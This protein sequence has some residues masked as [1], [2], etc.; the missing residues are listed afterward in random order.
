MLPDILVIG[1]YGEDIFIYGDVERLS[2]EGPI[3]ILKTDSYTQVLKNDGMAGNTYNNLKVLNPNL[4]ISFLSNS[5]PI[6]KTRFVDK[7]SGYILLRVDEN[8]NI[9]SNPSFS[10]AI[11]KRIE[12]S[13]DSLKAIVIS[14]YDKGLLSISELKEI[15]EL[16]YSFHLYVFLDTKKILGEWS[17]YVDFVKINEKEYL[18][19]YSQSKN[20][21][22]YFC[23]SLIVTL[24][25]K[26]CLYREKKTLTHLEMPLEKIIEVKDVSGAGDT[27]LAGFIT[28]YLKSFDVES[29][30]FFANRAATVAVSKQGV[31]TVSY[32]DIL[33]IFPDQKIN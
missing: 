1:E 28:E 15:I 16:A 10:E 3:P 30:L 25:N 2:P 17:K 9:E 18:Y 22:D 20:S 24:G 13:K 26:G 23:K 5:I 19:N 29:A 14:D 31:V 4:C 11:K 7:S 6:K 33:K 12:Q 21:G 32:E 8:D 27:F